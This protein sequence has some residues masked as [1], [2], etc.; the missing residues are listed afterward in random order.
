V[1]PAAVGRLTVVRFVVSLVVLT[2]AP[3]DCG[4]SDDKS[5]RSQ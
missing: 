3:F 2:F 1:G 4:P 5:S